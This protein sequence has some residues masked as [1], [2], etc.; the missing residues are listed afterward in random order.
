MIWKLLYSTSSSKDSG[1]LYAAR[2]VL[3]ARNVTKEPDDNFYASSDLIEKTTVSYIVTGALKIFGMN[4]IDSQPTT[5]I[6][7]GKIGD[8]EEMQKYLLDKAKS[9]VQ[10]YTLPDVPSLPTYGP[11]SNTLMCRYCNKMY[12]QRA[13]L[14]RHEAQVH[15]HYDPLYQNANTQT[16]EL[17][18]MDTSAV[19][20][21]YNYTRLC[22]TLGL[23]RLN[24][25]DAIHMGD[26]ERIMRI[27]NFLF[28]YYKSCGCT[29]YAY[30]ILE[31][32]A[33]S[34]ILLTD[35]QA[36]RLIW[37]R[38]VNHRGNFDSNHPNDLDI[39]HCNKV[40]KDQAHSYRGVFTE[41]SV[42]RV[43][44]SALK[45]HEV[46]KQFDR[47]CNVSISSGEHTDTNL[48]NDIKVLLGQFQ[49]KNLFENIPGR[50][51]SAFP[52]ISDNPLSALDMD[53]IQ[54]W[55]ASSLNKFGKK[56]FYRN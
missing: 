54:N 48:E 37:N 5:N 19:D 38:T 36:H 51:H 39:E 21:I 41:K 26:G 2:N 22:L 43:S 15:N 28:L 7:E 18:E 27:N 29:K 44:R 46:V 12:K 30:G 53:Y 6:Y 35:R 56:H 52:N 32:I 42:S 11:Q 9:F 23:F 47:M 13:A 20:G 33:Q 3:N 31:T 17:T 40:F 49:G 55:I 1:T 8:K 34:K 14:R 10:S 24:H 25:N 16:S 4:D 45:V 50:S